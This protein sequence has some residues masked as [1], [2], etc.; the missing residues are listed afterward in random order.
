[1]LRQVLSQRAL[2]TAAELHYGLDALIPPGSLGRV[3]GAAELLAAHFDKRILVVGDF[4]ADGATSCA[5]A[6]LGLR[7][8][9]ARQV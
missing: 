2:R 6:L 1:M 7:M 8:L 9:G 3:D 5:L 4:D